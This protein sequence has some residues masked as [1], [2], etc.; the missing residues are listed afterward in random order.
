MPAI[1]LI[2]GPSG[3]QRRE[4]RDVCGLS[5]AS[6]WAGEVVACERG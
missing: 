2:H 1:V 4:D 3:Y 6:G 5:A